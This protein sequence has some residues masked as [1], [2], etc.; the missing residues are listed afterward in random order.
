MKALVTGATGF[1]GSTLIDE[2]DTL[3]FEVHALVRRDSNFE[4]LKSLNCQKRE[5]DLSNYESLCLAAKGMDY[6]FHLAGATS[7]YHSSEYFK[8]NTEATDRIARAVSVSNKNLNRFVFISSLAAAGPAQSLVP[9]GESEKDQPVSD[10]GRS[11]LQAEARL[12]K[13]RNEFPVSIVRPPMVYGPRDKGVFRLIQAVNRNFIPILPRT[14]KSGSKYYSTIHV[15]DLCRGIVQAAMVSGDRVPSGEVFYL[16]DDHIYSD[17]ELMMVIAEKLNC[18]P[19]KIPIPKTAIQ[20]AATA[21]NA[22]GLVTRKKFPLNLD[23][24]NEIYAD[25]W[26]CSNSKARRLLKF[27]PEFDLVSGMAQSIAWYKRQGWI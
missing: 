18:N 26:I 6:V 12:L 10:Y 24:L 25:Y 19:M 5:G 20:A 13:Y 15:K 16:A 14:H 3:G 23:K 7:A 11:K 2:L 4:N 17:Q 8:Q 21:L 9:K 1:I 27:A 22:I